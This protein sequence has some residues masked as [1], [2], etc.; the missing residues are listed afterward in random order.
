MISSL[1]PVFAFILA[2]TILSL[3]S[4]PSR[5]ELFEDHKCLRTLVGSGEDDDG[6]GAEAIQF[7]CTEVN[8]T[9]VF[10]TTGNFSLETGA[11]QCHEL[12]YYYEIKKWVLYNQSMGNTERRCTRGIC[13][14]T[15]WQSNSQSPNGSL[16][17]LGILYISQ[18]IPK[19]AKDKDIEFLPTNIASADLSEKLGALSKR[20]ATMYYRAINEEG[21]LRGRVLLG[22]TNETYPFLKEEVDVTLVS[23]W[24]LAFSAAIWG[25]SVVMFVV[26]LFLRNRTFFDM[27]NPF[28]W[29]VAT[30]HDSSRSYGSVPSVSLGEHGREVIWIT[31]F[32]RDFKDLR[33]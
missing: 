27:T 3:S 16:P 23:S 11:V 5:G 33:Q 22:T 4:D 12:A 29:A 28:H 25:L 6:A 31:D 19:T 2:E 8:G 7:R 10:H 26:T 14:A 13:A 21:E 1:V 30:R 17:R 9:N 18:F 15:A 24:A 32:S 20:A